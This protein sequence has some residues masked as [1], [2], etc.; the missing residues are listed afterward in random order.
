V[1]TS[2]HVFATRPVKVT[3]AGLALLAAI[4]RKIAAR[5]IVRIGNNPKSMNYTE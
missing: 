5:A 3:S 4:A 1:A 2:V